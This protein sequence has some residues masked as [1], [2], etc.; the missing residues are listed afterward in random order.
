MGVESWADKL[1]QAWNNS[2]GSLISPAKAATHDSFTIN[3]PNIYTDRGTPISKLVVSGAG[4]GSIRAE[5]HISDT[6]IE[7]RTIKA[8]CYDPETNDKE[9]AETVKNALRYNQANVSEELRQWLNAAS[10]SSLIKS[11]NCSI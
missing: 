2:V 1:G 3:R 7:S 11:S 5:I 4:S 10:G 6:K 8:G 9:I